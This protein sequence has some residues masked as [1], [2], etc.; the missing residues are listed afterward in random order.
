MDVMMPL[1]F[2]DGKEDGRGWMEN[3]LAAVRD[4]IPAL[5]EGSTAENTL[6]AGTEAAET[7]TAKQD[8]NPGPGAE[9]G[10]TES[11]EQGTEE[12]QKDGTQ[13]DE[14]QKDGM[15][16]T[17]PEQTET[18]ITEPAAG[19]S[20]STAEPEAPQSVPEETIET[21][22]APREILY[23]EADTI[24]ET[25]SPDLLAD[26][27]ALLNRFFVVDP[28]TSVLP[29]EIDGS[30]LLGKDLTLP[31]NAEGPQIL[32][33]HT[34]SQE[35]FADSRPG[36]RADTVIGLGDDLQELLEK[37]YG[38]E[39]LHITEAFDMKEGCLE[40]SRAYNYAEP[41]IAAALEEHP[42][43]QVVID[44][45]R[46]GVNGSKRLVTEINGKPTAQIMFFNGLSRTKESGELTSLPNPYQA[47]NLA[48]SFQMEYEAKQY[49]PGFSRCIYLKGYRYNLHL[50]PRSVLLEVGAQTNTVEEVKNAMGP[51]AD[52]LHKVLLG[53]E[54]LDVN[55]L[56][57]EGKSNDI[58][59]KLVP[60]IV[61]NLFHGGTNGLSPSGNRD[62]K[63][64]TKNDGKMDC[65]TSHLTADDVLAANVKD[66]GDGTITMV[67]QP[68][69]ALL[70]TPGED[71]QGRFFNSLGDISSV[72]ESISVL[73]F[74][75]GTV[76]DN[77]VVDYKGGTGT[78]VI[79]TKT[80]EITKADYTMLVHIDVKHANVTVLKDKSASLDITYKCQYPASDDYLAGK[81]I[82]LTRVK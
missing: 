82:G 13:K 46:D 67:I 49:Y 18:G 42:S 29:G 21:G 25:I 6:S 44:L 5:R 28:N 43:I 63:G 47:E 23:P 48:F 68:K 58:I 45:H 50:R 15:E 69:E 30:T 10:Q 24:Q 75:Q 2:Y 22:G 33:Y 51:F 38:Y 65:T 27:Q 70:S 78:F 12:D 35:T 9:R 52:I 62:P 76:K 64:D 11:K 19:E 4:Q 72:V 80:N 37:Q 61:G 81:N 73:S 53:T 71:S 3:L 60:G 57:V 66:N 34:H 59:N 41:V 39:V 36:E 14:T 16:I 7:D 26:P 31:E 17:E 40:R 56:L 79:D 20:A 8:S 55:N 1:L 74:S 77:F 54:T 32:I